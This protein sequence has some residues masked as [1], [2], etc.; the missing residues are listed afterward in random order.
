MEMIT[1]TLSFYHIRHFTDAIQYFANLRGLSLT[2][3][4]ILAVI[5]RYFPRATLTPALEGFAADQAS[6]PP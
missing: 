5:F 3:F 2:H 4:Y 1:I 6:V